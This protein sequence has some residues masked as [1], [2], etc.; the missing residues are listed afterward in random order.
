MTER[1]EPLEV[2][3]ILRGLLTA[4]EDGDITADTRKEQGSL[5]QIRGAIAALEALANH[6]DP[7]P[8]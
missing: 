6:S 7:E 1:P 5:R 8:P 3:Q 4:I 2:A